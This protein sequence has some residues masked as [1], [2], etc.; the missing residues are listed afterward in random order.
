[1][2]NILERIL[3]SSS[4]KTIEV[5]LIVKTEQGEFI[6]GAKI[7]FTFDGPPETRWTNDEGYARVEIPQRDDID[8]DITKEGFK[9]LNKTMNLKA[10]PRRTRTYR[11]EKEEISDNS[12]SAGEGNPIIIYPYPG[13]EPKK[14]PGILPNSENG[15]TLTRP[16]GHFKGNRWL[17]D[18][19]Y[20][21]NVYHYKGTEISTGDSLRLTNPQ[22]SGNNNR[23]IYTWK[24]GQYKYQVIWQPGDPDFVRLQVFV[25]NGT[26]LVDDLLEK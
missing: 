14:P 2:S 20:E 17:L 25:P 18:L 5:E 7:Q 13:I 4:P 3:P 24:N 6:E 23:K 11:L 16:L 12:K 1:M 8:V 21:N 15:H 26:K 10:D 19:S 22:V 9:T